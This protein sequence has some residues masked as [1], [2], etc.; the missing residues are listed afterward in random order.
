MANE[1]LTSKS[2]ISTIDDADLAYFVDVSDT[3]SSP[4]GTGK[5]GLWSLIKST[6]KTYFDTLYIGNVVEDTTPQLGGNLSLNSNDI[7]GTGNIDISGDVFAEDSNFSR[8]G[9]AAIELLAGDAFGGIIG[10]DTAH[11]LT[12]RTNNTSRF[13]INQSTGYIS[14]GNDTTPSEKLTVQ[15]NIKAEDNM[16]ADQ[17]E[18]SALN[19]APA[20]ASSTG[21]LGEIRWTAT[22]VYLCTAT[23][24]WVRVA[25]ATW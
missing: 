2:S 1:K 3:T 13:I 25:L 14:I 8:D 6:L 22:H 10:T 23:N 11:N 21:T 5:K 9:V 4:T 19:S 17:Y 16:I 18:L 7:T 12:L 20:T 24:T 15:G